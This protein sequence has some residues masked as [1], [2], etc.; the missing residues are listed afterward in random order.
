MSQLLQEKDGISVTQFSRG[1]GNGQGF[2]VT[3]GLDKYVS[4]DNEDDAK[5]FADLLSKAIEK[6]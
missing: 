6:S 4:F 3:W 5:V 1:Q 2:Q